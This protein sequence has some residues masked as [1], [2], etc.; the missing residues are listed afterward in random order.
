M[1]PEGLEIVERALWFLAALGVAAGVFMALFDV[2]PG[3]DEGRFRTWCEARFRLL[4]SLSWARAPGAVTGLA[5][6]AVEHTVAYWFE[7]SERNITASGLFFFIVLI[8]VP[9]AALLS[10]VTGGSPALLVFILIVVLAALA[11][12]FLGETG[13]LRLLCGLLS[14]FLFASVF[15]ALPALVFASLTDR[16]LAQPVGHAAMGSVLVM[17]L[18]YLV[19]HSLALGGA[20][21]IRP[22]TPAADAAGLARHLT[23][24]LAALPIVYLLTF[25]AFL[26]GHLAVDRAALPANWSFL[27]AS[28]VAGGLSMSWTLA[29]FPGRSRPPLGWLGGFVLSLA[30]AFAATLGLA[31]AGNLFAGAPLS[32]E[33]SGRLLLGLSA[34]GSRILLGP[35]FWVAHTPFFPLL[36]PVL[37]AVLGLIGKGVLV[38]VGPWAR[39]EGLA[40]APMALAGAT[41]IL[42]GLAAAALARAMG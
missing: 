13:A 18:L 42:A 35:Q 7:P 32:W 28:L 3:R 39:R 31:M 17:P 1:G 40:T 15:F 20:L 8:A 30:G 33:E 34:D 37:P 23:H 9:A 10:A 5:A 12:M 25:A 14:V 6:G 36:L 38:A 29:L 4:E 26:V 16:L 22:F 24:F 27:I 19:S 41:L 11:L 21:I 2:G